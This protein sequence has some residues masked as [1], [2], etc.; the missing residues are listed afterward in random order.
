MPE[1]SSSSDGTRVVVHSNP[2]NAGQWRFLFDATDATFRIQNTV[3]GRC[4]DQ[5]DSSDS[6]LKVYSCLG[7]ESQKWYV[8]PVVPANDEA[9]ANVAQRYMIRHFTD[10]KCMDLLNSSNYDNAWVGLWDCGKLSNGEAQRNQRWSFNGNPSPEATYKAFL[11]NAASF[12]GKKCSANLSTCSWDNFQT[13]EPT[14]YAN[15]C[16]TTPAYFPSGGSVSFATAKET[17]WS[18]SLGGSFSASLETG[19]KFIAEA[20]ITY[21]LSASYQHTWSGS[22]TLT[23]ADNFNVDPGHWGWVTLNRWAVATT[24]TWVFDI[25]GFPWAVEDTVKVPQESG[26]GGQATA[27]VGHSEPTFTGCVG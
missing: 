16:S 4:I 23:T 25:G 12:G 19:F 3:T 27:L 2:G 10:N 22:E 14:L 11:Q 8:Q 18:D 1:N 6:N 9:V 15:E 20:K 5:P 21:T 7:Q 24:G 13:S 17:G 26:P